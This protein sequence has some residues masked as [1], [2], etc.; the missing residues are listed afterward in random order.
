MEILS[1]STGQTM[2]TIEKDTD[3][4]YYMD[5]AQAVEYG[6]VDQVLKSTK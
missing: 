6:L 1:E 3:R 4:N 2:E 5:A